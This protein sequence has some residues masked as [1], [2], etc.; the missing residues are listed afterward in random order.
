MKYAQ[1]L[2]L[3]TS[4]L[5]RHSVAPGVYDT[6][7]VARIPH[8]KAPTL[9]AYPEAVRWLLDHQ[10]GDG[11]WGGPIAY[12]H[13]RVVCTLASMLALAQWR[14]SCGALSDFSAR[15]EAAAWGVAAHLQALHRDP[16]PTS[17]FTQIVAQ[18]DEEVRFRGIALPVSAGRPGGRGCGG[19]G[20]IAGVASSDR[21]RGPRPA[22]P[23][24]PP[25]VIVPPANSASAAIAR[26]QRDPGDHRTR[27]QLAAMLGENGG[28]VPAS[29]RLELHECAWVLASVARLG[30]PPGDEV[31]GL[32]AA[33]PRLQRMLE[34]DLRTEPGAEAV[35][36]GVASLA[37]Q[38]LRWAGR[39]PDPT[40]LLRFEG[41]DHFRSGPQPG[42]PCASA[43][44][45]AHLLE[46]LRGAPAVPGRDRAVRKAV[47]VLARSTTPDHFWLD[48][49]HASPY[50]PTTHA[51]M[52]L[53]P[54]LTLA[55]E[56]VHF[57]LR[58]QRADGSWGYF[59]AGTAEETAYCL[60]A[61]SRFAIQG[62]TVPREALRAGA[63]WLVET[64][65]RPGRGRPLPPLWIGTSLL[66]PTRMV[67]AA[68]LAALAMTE[69]A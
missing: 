16:H 51:V 65:E 5:G 28:A 6:A 2:R 15:I 20:P 60:Q 29:A 7:L 61:L 40:W 45:H 19:P 62:G 10:F 32:A 34:A 39:N 43:T 9:P 49:G 26:L 37:F 59:D 25:V 21:R 36:L 38:V 41:D 63:A 22:R 69:A 35:D 8:A 42:A 50:L 23:L 54:Q 4:E 66:C 17:H 44:A 33:L 46:A 27:E 30:H 68:V 24:T 47:G 1:A 11:T 18:L 67:D 13:D 31:A 55:L 3:V 53:G 48:P 56:A 12:H 58:T 57:I 14:E 64:V 52:A